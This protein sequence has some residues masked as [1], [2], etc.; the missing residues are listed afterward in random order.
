MD[1]IILIVV[2]VL[3]LAAIG[4]R[5]GWYGAAGAIWDLLSLILFLILVFWILEVLGIVDVFA[6]AMLR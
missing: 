4:P 6:A 5:A 3:L 2:I 1:L